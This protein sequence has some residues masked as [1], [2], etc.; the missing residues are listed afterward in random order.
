MTGNL[1]PPVAAEDTG[2]A[3]RLG[4]TEARTQGG[5][6]DVRGHI[7]SYERTDRRSD[8]LLLFGATGDL[9]YK[10]GPLFRPGSR[11]AHEV[12]ATSQEIAAPGVLT[13]HEA[14][15]KTQLFSEG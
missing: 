7:G 12:V 13:M 1:A 4:R 10:Q 3:V 14:T 6:E 5:C 15:V 2:G 8:A 11:G 9:A